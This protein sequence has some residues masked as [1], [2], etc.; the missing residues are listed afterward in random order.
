M[1][2]VA[3]FSANAMPAAPPDNAAGARTFSTCQACHT[4]EKGGRNGIGPNLGGV[5][6]RRAGSVAGFNYS[7]AMKNSGIIWDAKVLDEF[8][9]AP[10]KKVPGTKMPISVLDPAK[11]AA[12][13]AYLSSRPAQ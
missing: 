8:L 10:T 4:I 6:G 1:A 9:A 3:V 5:I 13:I 7:A 11:R 12:L 2:P